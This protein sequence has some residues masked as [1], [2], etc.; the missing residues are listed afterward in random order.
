MQGQALQPRDAGGEVQGQVDRR[1]PRHDGRG[2][3]RFFKA[4]PASARS[5]RRSARRPR[6]HQCRP[7]GHH[8]LGRRS[9]AHQALQGAVGAPPAARSTSST[10]RPPACT[11]R[12]C[13]LLECC[14]SWSTRATRWSSSST[15][16]KSS[17][18]PT[19]SSISAPKAATPAARSSPSAPRRDRRQPGELYRP[20]PQAGAEA[21]G[22][23]Q[24]ETRGGDAGRGVI[25]TTSTNQ[26]PFSPPDVPCKSSIGENRR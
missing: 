21:P 15:I 9:A 8:A 16:S 11:S 12:T 5:C 17:R 14:T 26:S 10:S 23:R 4:V 6:L 2:R 20:L 13:Q 3:R 7:A 1:R 25:L 22:E 18:P 24:G 19:G